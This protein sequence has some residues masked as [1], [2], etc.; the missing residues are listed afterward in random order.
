MTEKV[1]IYFYLRQKLDE[2]EKQ[3]TQLVAENTKLRST[4]NQQS[5]QIDLIHSELSRLENRV[6]SLEYDILRLQ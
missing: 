5:K 2:L 6:S 1:D 4:Q 3:V